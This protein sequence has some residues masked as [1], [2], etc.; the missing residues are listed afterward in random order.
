MSVRTHRLRVNGEAHAV[1]V[2]G[3]TPLLYVLRNHL[4]LVATRFGCGTG[5]CGACRVLVDGVSVSSCDLPTSSVAERDIVTVEGIGTAERPHPIQRA[6]LYEQAGQC[7]YCL[8]GI[9]SSAFALLRRRSDPSEAE[10]RAAL[11]PHLCRCGSHNR[12]VRAI[13]RAAAEI[14]AGE[15][16]D[17]ADGS[18]SGAVRAS[19]VARGRSR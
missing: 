4:G 11:D 14:A 2:D 17:G 5:Q 7:G 1:D 10:I 3:E 13:L 19:T 8:S 9:Q 18:S 15:R 16:T 6:L 12:I